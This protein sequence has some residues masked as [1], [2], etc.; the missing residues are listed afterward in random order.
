V[1][2]K[3]RKGIK[4]GFKKKPLGCCVCVQEPINVR[5]RALKN[6]KRQW[7]FVFGLALSKREVL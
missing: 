1:G 7:Y 6:T 5:Q 4:I 2:P 3:K